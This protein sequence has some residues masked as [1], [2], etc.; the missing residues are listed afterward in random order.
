MRAGAGAFA[1]AGVPSR[2]GHGKPAAT[3]RCRETES[4]ALDETGMHP[5]GVILDSGGVMIR[6]IG[7]DWFSTASLEQVLA[8]CGIAWERDRLTAALA[9]GAAYLDAIHHMPLRDEAEERVVMARYHEIVLAGVGVTRDGDALAREIQSREDAREVVEPYEW[10]VEVLAGLQARSIPVVVLSNA[11]PSLRRL[12]RGLGLDR[13]VRAMVISA[14]E[15]AGKPDARVFHRALAALGL[16]PERTVFVDDWPG[17][18]EAANRLRIR[19]IWLRHDPHDP[20][21]GIETISDLREVLDI[22][23]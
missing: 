6:P 14:E 11:W 1:S 10:T 23:R 3:A 17:H 22:L 15:G 4:S 5:T 13:F 20:T 2:P 16:P 12:H 19:G 18:V 8:E 9:D 21:T 7:G